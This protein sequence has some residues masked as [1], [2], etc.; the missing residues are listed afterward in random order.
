MKNTDILFKKYLSATG[1]DKRAIWYIIK[2]FENYID[3][4][5]G[6]NAELKNIIILELFEFMETLNIR[7]SNYFSEIN[8]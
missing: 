8:N 7:F 5:C 4:E 2:R 1:G 6:D 3:Y